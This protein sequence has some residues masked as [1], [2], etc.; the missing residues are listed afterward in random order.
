MKKAKT[1]KT[2][3]SSK[4]L[5]AKKPTTNSLF[6][7]KG[8]Y[9]TNFKKKSERKDCFI[10]LKARIDDKALIKAAAKERRMPMSTFM[11][12][13]ALDTIR[14]DEIFKIK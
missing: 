5:K 3:K 11:L 4:V 2:K 10:I 9:N 8:K 6:G 13:C 14:N 1:L 12:L 7:G